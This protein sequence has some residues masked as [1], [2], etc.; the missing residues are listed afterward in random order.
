M[1]ETTKPRSTTELV[2]D[3]WNH[4]Q[5][6][7]PLAAWGSWQRALRV[8]PDSAAA[9]KAIATLET[10]ADLPLAARTA[11]RFRQPAD[12][13][14]RLWDQAMQGQNADQLTAMAELFGRLAADDPADWAAWY[15]RALC[16]AWVGDN[17]EAVSALDRVVTLTAGTAFDEAVGA[18]ALA[19]VLRQG[20]GAEVLADDLRCVVTIDWSVGETAFLLGEFPEIERIELPRVPGVPEN[21]VADLEVFEWLSRHGVGRQDGRPTGASLPNVFANRLRRRR[22]A[23]AF[24]SSARDPDDGGGMAAAASSRTAAVDSPRGITAAAGVPRCRRLDFPCSGSR[25]CRAGAELRREAVEDYYEN[26]WI[27]RRRQGLGGKSPLEAAQ[28]ARQGDLVARQRLAAVVLVREQLADRRSA[29]ALY[30]G[31]PFDRLRRRL[32]LD[33]VDAETV[34]DDDLSCAPPDW[35]DRLD[36]AALEPA[37]LVDAVESAAGLRDDSRT[38]R[39]A[40]A[41]LRRRP[42][43][44]VSSDL[45]LSGAVAPSCGGRCFGK[46]LRWRLNWIELAPLWQW[47]KSRSSSRP[48]APKS[49]PVT[50]G[51]R[52]RWRFIAA[53]LTRTPPARHCA[54]D[55]AETMLDNG[56]HDEAGSLLRTARDLAHRTGRPSIERRA[57]SSS[58]VSLDLSQRRSA[59]AATSS[60]MRGCAS[61]T[62]M[63]K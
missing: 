29:R 33:R 31:Y 12:P 6:E 5:Q 30:H 46:T 47:A 3:G 60:M 41:L 40:A 59:G 14:P 43:V 22:T 42:E 7:R 21:H 18:W 2:R 61:R 49:W 15:N 36:P 58:R 19:E 53:S 39:L 57:A 11:Y 16:L 4:L 20:A 8:E 54:L 37:R 48:G 10:A 28:A 25:G 27:H 9:A 62:G 13:A 32:G 34:E 63:R 52:P 44:L 24:Q 1:P 50:A 45:G 26:I 17:L 35:L 23:A 55:A 38:A 56:H 51:P